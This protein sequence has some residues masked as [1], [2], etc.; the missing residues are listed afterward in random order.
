VDDFY[1]NDEILGTHND[2]D[3]FL[4]KSE[5]MVKVCIGFNRDI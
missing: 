4:T 2:L 5:E 1:S 3:F